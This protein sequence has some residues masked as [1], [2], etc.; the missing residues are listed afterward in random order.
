MKKIISSLILTV[1]LFSPIQAHRHCIDNSAIQ[2]FTW[3]SLGFCC[4]SIGL[5]F[6]SRLLGEIMLKDLK[7][8]INKIEIEKPHYDK[9]NLTQS[10]TISIEN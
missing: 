4:C 6:S 7:N 9:E 2:K 1:F 5:Y 3:F 10:E 8:H